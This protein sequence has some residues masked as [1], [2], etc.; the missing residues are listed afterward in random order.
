MFFIRFYSER[1]GE[2][3][4][5]QSAYK[6]SATCLALTSKNLNMPQYEF[7]NEVQYQIG[8]TKYR[9]KNY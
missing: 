5:W 8:W 7:V 2:E 1:T 4:Y 3:F 6:P 9:R